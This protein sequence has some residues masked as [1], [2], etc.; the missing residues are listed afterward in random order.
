MKEGRQSMRRSNL[1]RGIII[2]SLCAV[3]F[4]PCYTFFFLYPSFERL[5]TEKTE[6]EAARFASHMATMFFADEVVLSR[7]SITD[8]VTMGIEKIAKDMQLIK[9]KVFSPAGEVLYSTDA[10]DIGRMNENEYFHELVAK[11]NTFTKIVKK[12]AR[13]L[14]GQLMSRDVVE[15]YAPLVKSGRFAGAFELYY[16]ITKSREKLGVL[17]SKSTVI[18][19][20]AALGLMLGVI[21]SA[22]NAARSI[23][24]RDSAEGELRKHRDHLEQLVE[25]R[26]KEIM[27]ANEQIEQ[28]MREKLQAESSL[29]DTEAKYRSLVESTEDSIYLVDADLRYLFINKKHAR[30]MGAD[31]DQFA[32]RA[33]AEFHTADQSE[34]FA[35]AVREVFESGRSRQSEHRSERDERY[36]LQT[37][38]PVKDQAG[39]II[40]VTVVSKDIS[41]RRKMEEE[42]RSLSLTDP[43]TGLHNR[44]GFLTLVGQYLKIANRMQSKI[45]ILYADLDDLKGINDSFGHTE[46]DRAL[47][48]AAGVLR[49]TF[50][51]SDIVARIGGDEFVVMPAV[52]SNATL[53]VIV[54]RLKENIEAVNA[55]AGRNYRLSISYGI[56]FYDPENPCTVDELLSQGDRLMYEHKK[57]KIRRNHDQA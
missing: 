9:V 54:G 25:A 49:E 7:E 37:L 39:G 57:S 40:A 46:G 56:A 43:L 11:G 27:R 53:E 1:L 45:S 2:I 21:F 6:E 13:S 30:R 14:E 50:R 12:S 3:A 55:Q 51:E 31:P 17:T 36:F 20:T 48:E 15:T 42:L 5:L 29:L 32:G 16:D 10:G 19:F 4:L 41:D 52:L 34:R 18:V 44:R 33:Y 26:T 38:S 8:R 35:R 28:E 23:R 22:L 24:E 47:I